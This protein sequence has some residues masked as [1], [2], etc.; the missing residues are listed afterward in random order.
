MAI[1][2]FTPDELEEI[3]VPFECDSESGLA[4]E[5]HRELWDTTRWAHVYE[6]VFRAPDDGKEK[7]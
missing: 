6:F 1:R 4:A 5:L 3:G 2:T 7:I